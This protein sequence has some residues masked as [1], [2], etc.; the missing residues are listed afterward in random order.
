ME[1]NLHMPKLPRIPYFVLSVALDVLAAGTR[2]PRRRRERDAGGQ[3][4]ARRRDLRSAVRRHARG[5]ARQRPARVGT[6][7]RAGHRGAGI[8]GS[9]P[10]LARRLTDPT[11][12]YPAARYGSAYE[13]SGLPF[14]ERW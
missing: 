8:L 7:R 2:R 5:M 3:V 10:L 14:S 13:R 11:S 9:Q 4:Q 1:I 6:D 12:R